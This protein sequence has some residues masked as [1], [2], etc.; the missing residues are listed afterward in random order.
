MRFDKELSPNNRFLGM[1]ESPSQMHIF[2]SD[3]LVCRGWYYS[4]LGGF[5]SIEVLI[6]GITIGSV[7]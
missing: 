3:D 7:T 2:D 1:I 6:D 4:E 5:P